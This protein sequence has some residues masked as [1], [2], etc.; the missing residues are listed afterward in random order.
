[1]HD[2]I[3]KITPRWRRLAHIGHLTVMAHPRLLYFTLKGAL[4]A[5]AVILLIGAA[6]VIGATFGGISFRRTNELEH[7]VNQLEKAIESMATSDLQAQAAPPSASRFPSFPSSSSAPVWPGNCPSGGMP[8]LCVATAANAACCT[9]NSAAIHSLDLRVDSLETTVANIDADI[10]GLANDLAD[11]ADDVSDL[12]GVVGQLSGE[13][14]DLSGV[15]SQLVGDVSDLSDELDELADDLAAV[16]ATTHS[17]VNGSVS[18]Y[19]YVSHR[20]PLSCLGVLEYAE[21][22]Y[23]ARYHNLTWVIVHVPLDDWTGASPVKHFSLPDVVTLQPTA[24]TADEFFEAIIGLAMRSYIQCMPAFR[25]LNAFDDAQGG[26]RRLDDG[27]KHVF[28]RIAQLLR[29]MASDVAPDYT[30][31]GQNISLDR[32]LAARLSVDLLVSLDTWVNHPNIFAEQFVF[33]QYYSGNKHSK[34]SLVLHWDI[35]QDYYV[36]WE[37]MIWGFSYALTQWPR[38]LPPNLVWTAEQKEALYLVPEIQA[39]ASAIWREAANLMTEATDKYFN[40][41]YMLDPNLAVIF[42]DAVDPEG[43]PAQSDQTAALW[44]SA[45]NQIDL[46]GWRTP[47]PG[48]HDGSMFADFRKLDVT[49]NAGNPVL[50]YEGSASSQVLFYTLPQVMTELL[51]AVEAE[52]VISKWEYAWNYICRPQVKRFADAVVARMT[53]AHMS[54]D[55]YTGHWRGAHRHVSLVERNTS[56]GRA[57]AYR[58]PY[59]DANPTGPQLRIPLSPASNA[60]FA[61]AQAGA[62]GT[63]TSALTARFVDAQAKIADIEQWLASDLENSVAAHVGD[64]Y[65]VLRKSNHSLGISAGNPYTDVNQIMTNYAADENVVQPYG[66][67]NDIVEMVSRSGSELASLF[68]DI[69]ELLA[70]QLVKE[71]YAQ[72]GFASAA[73]AGLYK[74]NST[75]VSVTLEIVQDFA[76]QSSRTEAKSDLDCLGRHYGYTTT[77]AVNASEP[78]APIDYVYHNCMDYIYRQHYAIDNSQPLVPSNRFDPVT[79]LAFYQYTNLDDGVRRAAFLTSFRALEA[80]TRAQLNTG[81][82]GTYMRFKMDRNLQTLARYVVDTAV[83]NNLLPADFNEEYF[84]STVI[85]SWD[86]ASIAA[87]GPQRVAYRVR[88]QLS[89]SANSGTS[90]DF[91]RQYV[92]ITISFTTIVPF[93][94]TSHLGTMLHEGALGHGFD[95]VPNLIDVLRGKAPVTGWPT[96]ANTVGILDDSGIY[97]Y[98]LP[99]PSAGSLGEGWATLGEIIGVVNHYYVKFDEAGNPIP[100]S[101]DTSAALNAIISLARIAARQVSAVGTNFARHAWSFNR[102]LTT[103]KSLTGFATFTTVDFIDRFYLHPMQQTSYANGFITNVGLISYLTNRLA[104]ECYCFDLSKFIEFRITRTDYIAGASL[105]EVAT[106]NIYTFRTDNLLPCPGAPP[107]TKKRSIDA[108]SQAVRGARSWTA[109]QMPA[110]PEGKTIDFEQLLPAKTMQTLANSTLPT[111]LMFERRPDVV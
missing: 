48:A 38:S 62:L 7:D 99:T 55:H 60:A 30:F 102:L 61:S 106:Q 65:L 10:S 45:A 19:A 43:V 15:V 72:F 77:G 83:V 58:V 27:T 24:L 13:V 82:R 40:P 46:R 33:S 8:S 92:N 96:T 41:V 70:D 86:P 59:S 81:K 42:S 66:Q 101:Q 94:A 51:G 63:T 36:S 25:T 74:T 110:L 21:R 23:S 14:S 18:D 80:T 4:I 79:G 50:R 89:G 3:N 105:F 64:I 44:L 71:R 35:F 6:A 17:L 68:F 78:D 73:S 32:L 97:N 95:R 1:M 31:Y 91:V 39:A 87:T 16:N 47:A 100:G 103:F 111:W 109:D 67:P 49:D 76:Q 20:T 26:G 84:G 57:I 53:P 98:G 54:N 107:C 29:G 90:V 88:G 52:K 75:G 11:L 56:T 104:S 93:V 69:R 12:S 37:P 2:I 9:A 5:L 28:G 108:G 34:I 22:I 85:K